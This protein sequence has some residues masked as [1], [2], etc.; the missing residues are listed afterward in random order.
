MALDPRSILLGGAIQG[1]PASS[2]LG[3]IQAGQGITR[4]NLLNQQLEGQIAQ[5]KITNP[6]QAALLEQQIATSAANQDVAGAKL[7]DA[8]GKIDDNERTRILSG[9]K[10]VGSILKPFIETGDVIGATGQLPLIESLNLPT[11]SMQDL[12]KLLS[13]GSLTEL[14]Q[15]IAN[16]EQ[17]SIPG[18]GSFAIGASFLTVDDKGNQSVVVPTSNRA[19][20]ELTLRTETIGGTV[21]RKTTGETVT[22]V[23]KSTTRLV[24]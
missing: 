22:N 15:A 8:Q 21:A 10:Q 6:L 1:G 17:L 23:W 12:K 24:V 19:T 7:Q 3:G 2:F 20:G 14:S 4:Q 18:D 5:A 11:E 13:E 9:L 16:I